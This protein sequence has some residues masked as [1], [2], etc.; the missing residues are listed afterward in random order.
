MTAFQEKWKNSTDT[1]GIEKT[2]GDADK[3]IIENLELIRKELVPKCKHPKKMRDKTANG[4][5][6][7][8][9]CNM[10]LSLKPG[11]SDILKTNFQQKFL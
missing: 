7:C 6:Y 10:D 3:R 11:N 9:N 4:Q 5:L 8:M 2:L 1:Y